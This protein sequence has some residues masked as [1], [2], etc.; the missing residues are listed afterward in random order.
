[1][2]EDDCLRNAE[3]VERTPDQ[4]GLGIRRPN[5]VAGTTAVAE[6]G[7][8]DNN[9]SVVLGGQV[10]QPTG[11]EIL[12][13]AAV[14]VQK[15]QRLARASLHVVQADPVHLKK[16][17]GRRIVMLRLLGQMTVQKR[18]AASAPAATIA[19]TA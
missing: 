17:A 15:H 9:N 13:H 2:P 19:A 18:V 11:Y 7:T 16:L 8:V 12:D 10:D 4:L 5:D 3:P 6:T 14:S 1:V